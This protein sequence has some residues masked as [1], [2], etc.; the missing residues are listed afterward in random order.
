MSPNL[1]AGSAAEVIPP[2]EAELAVE[3]A[4][5]RKI[6]Q[7]WA[8]TKTES[9]SVER[10]HAQVDRLWPQ[11]DDVKF[12]NIEAAVQVLRQACA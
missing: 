2:R 5:A 4:M 1:A 6:L 11:E 10:T 12:D 9:G 7:T 3:P 8:E